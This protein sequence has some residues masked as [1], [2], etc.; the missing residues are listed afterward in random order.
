MVSFLFQKYHLLNNIFFLYALS[1]LFIE[2]FYIFFYTK[3]EMKERMTTMKK[4]KGNRCTLNHIIYVFNSMW[5]KTRG[6]NYRREEKESSKQVLNIV[7]A[8]EISTLDSSIATD[9]FSYAALNN[10]MEGLYMPD[11]DNKPVPAAAESYK[12]SEDGKHIYIYITRFKMVKWRSS[13]CP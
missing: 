2:I 8:G 5:S 12:L 6:N 13:N 7:E 10:V 9:G 11:P 1:D 4:N 3:A